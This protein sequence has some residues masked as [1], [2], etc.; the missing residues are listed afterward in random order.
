MEKTSPSPAWIYKRD[1]RLVPFESDKISQSLFAVTESLNRPDA[2]TARELTDSV[3]HFMTAELPD[4][5]P[6]ATQV[7]DLVIKVVR[8][9]GQT[10]IAQAY[11]DF[12]RDK[13]LKQK[14]AGSAAGVR[15]EADNTGKRKAGFHLDLPLPEILAQHDPRSLIRIVAGTCFHEYSLREIFTRDIAAAHEEGLISL[16]GLDTP[17]EIQG[18]VL[19]PVE[20]GQLVET[21]EEARRTVGQ[22]VC[23]DSLEFIEQVSSVASTAEWLHAFQI[24]LR[25]TGLHA[26]VNLNCA[27]PPLWAQNLATGPLFTENKASSSHE[28]AESPTDRL[29][30]QILSWKSPVARI[31]WHL[32]ERDFHSKNTT[33]VFRL[34]RLILEGSPITVVFDRPGRPVSLAEGMDRQHSSLLTTVGLHLP[35]MAEQAGVLASPDR[36]LQKLG[37]LARLALTAAVQKRRFLV[38]YRRHRPA[39]LVDRARLAVVPVGL[40]E[41]TRNYTGQRILPG[42][43]GADFACRIVQTLHETLRE[44]GPMYSLE[45]C[46]DSP[47]TSDPIV[48]TISS[49]S[50]TA[51]T[52]QELSPSLDQIAG[53]TLWND[54]ISLREQVQAAS[55]LQGPIQ[56]GT[57]WILLPKDSSCNAEEL[58]DTL[59]FAWK[60]TGVSRLRFVNE[61]RL[62]RQLIAPW[63]KM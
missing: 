11:A 15:R 28:I 21:I 43:P 24:G 22:L 14:E 41:V 62:G 38:R 23:L 20:T 37:S 59:R 19:I 49:V 12:A 26:V 29:L 55:L 58:S 18:S 31:Q 30:D 63:E 6:K 4:A 60:E 27:S 2:F 54:G 13:G 40:E 39:F 42:S 61:L 56:A 35:R 51:L 9:L 48:T 32:G 8:E 53:L 7:A 25:A 57:A 47:P 1:G 16:A 45:A 52:K 17:F 44:E 5:I 34:A 3:L 46:L 36:F 33:R 50:P 10:A